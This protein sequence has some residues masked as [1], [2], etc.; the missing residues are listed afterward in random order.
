MLI[1]RWLGKKIVLVD[2]S[3]VRGTTSVKIVQMMRD[4]ELLKFIC[5]LLLLQLPILIF[6]VLIRQVRINCWRQRNLFR[7]WVIIL[8]LIVYLFSL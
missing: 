2:D 1:V 7:R 4:A 6:T 3:I 8:G 5:E